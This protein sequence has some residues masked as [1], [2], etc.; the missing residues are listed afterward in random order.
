[1]EVHEKTL[2]IIKPDILQLRKAGKIISLVEACGLA[3]VAMKQVYLSQQQAA[4]FYAEHHGK[5]FFEAQTAFMSSGPV[6]A[7]I[8]EGTSAISRWR[9]LMGPTDPANA[10]RETI[11][12]LFGTSIQHNAVHGSDSPRSATQEIAFFFAGIENHGSNPYPDSE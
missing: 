5:S 4:L 3:I 6:I 1:M 10:P 7:L 11:R 9:A 8:L 2:A 12:K